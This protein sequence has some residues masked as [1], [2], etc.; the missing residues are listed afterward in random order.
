MTKNPAQLQVCAALNTC[1]L[2][3]WVSI[4]T[5]AFAWM[6]GPVNASFFHTTQ[7]DSLIL[8]QAERQSARLDWHEQEDATGLLFLQRQ[9]EQPA[10]K[11]R[12]HKLIAAHPQERKRRTVKQ[13]RG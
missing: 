10:V 2:L 13:L 4:S 5:V 12:T 11:L 3:R 6:A 9:L 1:T 8:A 7:P